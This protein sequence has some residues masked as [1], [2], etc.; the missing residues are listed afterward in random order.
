M[1]DRE[2]ARELRELGALIDYPPTPD[3]A[4]TVRNA[5]EEAANDQPR[6]LRM[7]FPTM[8]WVAVAAAFVL[9]IAVPTLSQVCVPR[10][11]TGLWRTISEAPV[12]PLSMPAHLRDSQRH[13]P[14]ASPR[15]A[16]PPRWLHCSRGSGSACARRGLRWTARSSCR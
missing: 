10:S 2:L 11:A 3:I 14:L 4:R 15:V 7:S 5:L 9:L 12:G 1:P 6:R 13:P 16:H 8:R